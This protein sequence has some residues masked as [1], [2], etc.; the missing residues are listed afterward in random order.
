ME[1]TILINEKPPFTTKISKILDIEDHLAY[2]IQCYIIL[3]YVDI[4]TNQ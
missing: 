2:N 1:V 3:S 4:H